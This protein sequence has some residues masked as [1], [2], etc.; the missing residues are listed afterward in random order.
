MLPRSHV[1]EFRCGATHS[2]GE[3]TDPQA[4]PAAS[5]GD[6]SGVPLQVVPALLLVK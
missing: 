3:P 1:I 2:A 4:A 5:S 6:V